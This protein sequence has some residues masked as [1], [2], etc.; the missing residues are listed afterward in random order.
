MAKV[1]VFCRLN[2]CLV[3]YIFLKLSQF[4]FLWV[5]PKPYPYGKELHPAFLDF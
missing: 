5:K 4:L 2:R 3:G 1:L